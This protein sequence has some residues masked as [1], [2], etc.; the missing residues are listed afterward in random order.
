MMSITHPGNTESICKARFGDLPDCKGE[1][2]RRS[3]LSSLFSEI[4]SSTVGPC[5]YPTTWFLHCLLSLS[6]SIIFHGEL[7]ISWSCQVYLVCRH[8]LQ[9]TPFMLQKLA[10]KPR[11]LTV[12]SWRLDL[13]D[14]GCGRPSSFLS[15]ELQWFECGNHKAHLVI[16]HWRFKRWVRR[17]EKS[18]GS[19]AGCREPFASRWKIWT[20]WWEI[21]IALSMR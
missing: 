15:L 8:E 11:S 18:L 10:Q 2:E 9:P 3:S 7:E 12:C 14:E 20:F 19:S 4:G 13:V 16:C 21:P 1:A 17:R 6:D 5:Q